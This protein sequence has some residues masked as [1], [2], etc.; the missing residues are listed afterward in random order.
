[1]PI[2]NI[3]CSGTLNQSVDL[4]ILAQSP[5]IEVIYN[6]KKYHGAYLVIENRKITIYK[7]GKYIITGLKKIEDVLRFYELIR[8]ALDGVLD[9]T[10][11]SS[12]IIQNIVIIESLNSPVNLLSVIQKNPELICEYE[13]E[14]FP[15]LIMKQPGGTILLFSTGKMVLT[16]LKS[17]ENGEKL[18]AF[19]QG[20][21]I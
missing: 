3:V 4:E 14:Q 9:V 10:C 6:P 16:G 7:S 13:P 18:K 11:I 15:G 2:I 8:I 21:V 5:D 12:P 20:V 1:M 19:V 17:I